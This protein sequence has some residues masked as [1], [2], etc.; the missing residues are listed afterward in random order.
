[1]IDWSTFFCKSPVISVTLLSQIKSTFFFWNNLSWSIFSALNFSLLWIIWTFL[2]KLDKNKAKFSK[3][4][5][6]GDENEL[7]WISGLPEK[8]TII[9][10]GH[11]FVSNGD[12]VNYRLQDENSWSTL[13]II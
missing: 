4:E 1:M 6:L 9:T 12:S 10:V 3:V 5:I 7:V 11:E 13:L 8:V 2:H